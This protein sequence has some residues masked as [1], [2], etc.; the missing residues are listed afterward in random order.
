M[1]NLF[2]ML[3]GGKSEGLKKNQMPLLPVGVYRGKLAFI[4]TSH[5]TVKCFKLKYLK[6]FFHFSAKFHWLWAGFLS[7]LYWRVESQKLELSS[8]QSKNW[9]H[10]ISDRYKLCLVGSYL[11][12]MPLNLMI[13]LREI[14]LLSNEKNCLKNVR[15]WKST[16]KIC[17]SAKLFVASYQNEL[18]E[19]QEFKVC[20]KTFFILLI[21]WY[22]VLG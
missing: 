4:R 9:E 7:N 8:V 17:C 18:C 14:G 11:S 20:H 22:Y 5:T 21:L 16:I 12:A 15:G 1:K 13:E 6:A 19:L 3:F 10:K 2:L